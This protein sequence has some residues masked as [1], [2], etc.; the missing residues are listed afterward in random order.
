M[1]AKEKGSPKCNKG[2][3]ELP[4]M[5]SYIPLQDQSEKSSLLWKDLIP[6]VV[7]RTEGAHR[8]FR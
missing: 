7:M 2:H 1:Q 4:E 3:Q 6:L 8:L 5:K